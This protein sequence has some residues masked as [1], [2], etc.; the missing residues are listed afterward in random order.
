MAG[1]LSVELRSSD[2]REA[3]GAGEVPTAMLDAGVSPTIATGRDTGDGFGRDIVAGAAAANA[4]VSRAGGGGGPPPP[5]P[6]PPAPPPA[7]AAA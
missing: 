5:P 3:R 7:P 4:F 6:P 2:K 1:N